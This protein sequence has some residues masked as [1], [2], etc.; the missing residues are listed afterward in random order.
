ML[1]PD[2]GDYETVAVIGAGVSGM[3]VAHDLAR[4]R[5]QSHRLRSA[6]ARRAECSPP[7]FPFSACRA[8]W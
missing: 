8:N 3:T 6:L 5:I 7:A 4:T 2:R 1:P